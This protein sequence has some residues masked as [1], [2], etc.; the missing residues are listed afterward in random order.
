MRKT[1]RLIDYIKSE[2][3]NDGLDSFKDKNRLTFFDSDTDPMSKILAYDDDVSSVVDIKLF[4]G[5]KLETGDETFKRMFVNHFL[6]REIQTQTIDMFR[7][8]MMSMMYQNADFLNRYYS[9]LD[10]YIH[11]YQESESKTVGVDTGESTSKT[12]TS[13]QTDEESE[14]DERQLTSTLPQNDV[15]IDL[16]RDDLTYADSN[17]ITKRG[18]ESTSQTDGVSETKSDNKTDKEQDVNT[19]GQQY[20]YDVLYQMQYAMTSVLNKFDKELFLQIW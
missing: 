1:V 19:Q 5:F 17:T 7:H 14:S 16:N 11:G 9:E 6:E 13:S 8:R 4:G 3:Y 12:E 10:K 15:N 18:S 2:L 20:D